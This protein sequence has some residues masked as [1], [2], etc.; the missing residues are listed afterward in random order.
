MYNC[1]IMEFLFIM[2]YLKLI[3]N[4][5]YKITVSVALCSYKSAYSSCGI[6]RLII[7]IGTA[8]NIDRRFLVVSFCFTLINQFFNLA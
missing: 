5:Y 6:F 2:F 7:H 3:T 4:N 8:E 1:L